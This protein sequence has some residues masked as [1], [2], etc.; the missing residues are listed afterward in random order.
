MFFVIIEVNYKVNF[1][2]RRGGYKVDEFMTP[3]VILTALLY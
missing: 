2:V 3:K 1:D